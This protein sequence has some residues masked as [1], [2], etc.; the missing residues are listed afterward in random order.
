[1]TQDT[2]RYLVFRRSATSF[3]SFASARKTTIRKGL[4]L[5]EARQMCASFNDNRTPAQIAA[6]TKYEFTAQ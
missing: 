5:A 4:T 1:M 3:E 2:T 6:G